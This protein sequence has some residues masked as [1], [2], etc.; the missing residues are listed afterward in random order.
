M[1]WLNCSKTRLMLIVF[2]AAMF[3]G[4]GIANADFIWAQKADMPTMRYDFSTS[5]LSGLS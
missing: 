5:T 4:G 3:I 2:L 1:R